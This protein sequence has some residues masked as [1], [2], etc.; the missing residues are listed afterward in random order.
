IAHRHH[1]GLGLPALVEAQHARA[2]LGHDGPGERGAVP[3]RLIAVAAPHH[4]LGG[5]EFVDLHAKDHAAV[6]EAEL[7]LAA[8][9]LVRRGVRGPP[10]V[11]ALL[12]NDTATTEIYTLS[13]RDALPT[14]RPVARAHHGGR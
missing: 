8:D 13:V 9:P 12:C 3:F 4:A 10:A 6:V 1:V 7:R 14:L 11:W 5:H 2:V